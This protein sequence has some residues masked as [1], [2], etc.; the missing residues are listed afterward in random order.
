MAGRPPK[1]RFGPKEH[2]RLIEVVQQKYGSCTPTNLIDA[3]RNARTVFAHDTELACKVHEWFT[4]DDHEAAA[5]QRLSEA[6]HLVLLYVKRPVK[7]SGKYA[8][9]PMPASVSVPINGNK[10]DREYISTNSPRGEMELLRQAVQSTYGLRQ[11]LKRYQAVLVSA[12]MADAVTSG[13]ALAVR[14]E[15]YL[16]KQELPSKNR[17]S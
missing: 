6:R 8:V 9:I 15:R 11:W 13:E 2:A 4:W 10:R 12:G 7:V 17:A 5:K 16:N 14:I 3:A 1:P